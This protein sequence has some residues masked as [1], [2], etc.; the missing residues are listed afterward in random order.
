MTLKDISNGPEWV[1]WVVLAIFVVISIVLL[2]GHGSNLIAGYNTATKEEK[3]KY[4]DKKLCKITG[5]GM[6]VITILI[7]VRVQWEEVLPASFAYIFLAVTL[8]DCAVMIILLNT[9]CKNR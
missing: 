6:S 2:S 1:T 4:D 8:I 5:A 9:I 3:S 7:F